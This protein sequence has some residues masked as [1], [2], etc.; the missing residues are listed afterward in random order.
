[1]RPDPGPGGDRERGNPFSEVFNP[2]AVSGTDSVAVQPW[3]P[4]FSL[5]YITPTKFR[6]YQELLYF[7]YSILVLYTV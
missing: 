4:L 3:R 2:H 1:M 5:G 6:V 7:K